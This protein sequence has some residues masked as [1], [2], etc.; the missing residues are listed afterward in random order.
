MDRAT[1]RTVVEILMTRYQAGKPLHVNRPDPFQVLVG[2]MLS[3]RTRDEKT[4][5]AFQKLLS[6]MPDIKS[7]A[8]ARVRDI[9]RTI[10]DVGFYR[11]KARRVREVARIILNQYGGRV[12]S[13]RETLMKLPGVGPKTADIVLSHAFGRAEVAVDTHV[14]AVAKRL[15]LVEE[16]ADYEGVKKA[17][18]ELA[19]SRY[20]P[21]I[22]GL[23]VSFGRDVC[24]KP[25]PKCGICPIRSYCRYYQLLIS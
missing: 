19:E 1:F 21:I 25:I 5:R 11:Q 12:P 2:A 9:E 22:N 8:A 6:R 24:R 18:H 20:L 16:N 3:H 13:D 17:I 4:D 10:R 14:D 23:L 15:G 7:I